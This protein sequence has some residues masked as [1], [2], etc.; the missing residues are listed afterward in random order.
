MEDEEEHNLELLHNLLDDLAISR[1]CAI[2][3]IYIYIYVC[4]YPT[5]TRVHSHTVDKR[6]Q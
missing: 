1:Q 4:I 6:F 5:H 2:I 3:Y